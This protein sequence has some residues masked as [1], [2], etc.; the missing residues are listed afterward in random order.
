MT[1]EEL[2]ATQQ[3]L[4]TIRLSGI[5]FYARNSNL[6][7]ELGEKGSAIAA[8]FKQALDTKWDAERRLQ[9]LAER[10][11]DLYGGET[12]RSTSEQITGTVTLTD[13]KVDVQLD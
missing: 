12:F 2:H 6:R 4:Q 9:S 3:R 5:G 8:E 7:A 10:W 1:P 13:G 11:R